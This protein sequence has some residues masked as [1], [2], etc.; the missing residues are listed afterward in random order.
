MATFTLP[1]DHQRIAIVTPLIEGG[2]LAGI[3]NWRTRIT[4]TPRSHGRFSKLGLGRK[5]AEDDDLEHAGRLDEE[6]IKAVTKQV[7]EGLTYLHVNGFLHASQ[8]LHR[9]SDDADVSQRDLKAGNI[10]ASHDGTILLADFGVGGDI[11]TALTPVGRPLPLVEELHFKQANGLLGTPERYTRELSPVM[12]MSD[13]IGKRKSFVGTV[14]R[15]FMPLI[16][17]C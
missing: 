16:S 6:E 17:S 3:L 14:S 13:D 15:V 12:D 9:R 10:L 11:N 7:L 2:S 1:P 5:S 4:T 8:R